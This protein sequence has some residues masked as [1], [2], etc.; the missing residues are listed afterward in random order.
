MRTKHQRTNSSGNVWI[1][2]SVF[3]YIFKFLPVSDVRERRVDENLWWTHQSSWSVDNGSSNHGVNSYNCSSNHGVN[4]YDCNCVEPVFSLR[5]SKQRRGRSTAIQA[6]AWSVDG[7]PSNGVVGRRPSKQRRGRST[8]RYPI[9]G[10]I[11]ARLVII[12]T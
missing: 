11:F 4:S 8:S 7:H 5:P 2:F 6:T 10:E 1:N 9:Y 3:H 12:L